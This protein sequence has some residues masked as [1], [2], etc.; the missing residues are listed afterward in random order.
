MTGWKS[1]GVDI[2][3]AA[4]GIAVDE[5]P[6]VGSAELA[7]IIGDYNALIVRSKTKVTADLLDRAQALRIVGRAGT[8]VDNID[9]AAATRRGV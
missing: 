4:S 3:R 8:G 1:P 7:E 2:L 5:R 6:S 9:V